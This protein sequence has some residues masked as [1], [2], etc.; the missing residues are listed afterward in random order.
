MKKFLLVIILLLSACAKSEIYMN[1]ELLI[2]DGAYE[3]ITYPITPHKQLN[4]YIKDY[5][6]SERNKCSDRLHVDNEYE[7]QITYDYYEYDTFISLLFTSYYYSNN[8]EITTY[9]PLTYDTQTN[10]LQ[11]MD[12][13]GYLNQI[14]F[15][16]N[17]T[18]IYYLEHDTLKS[19][20]YNIQIQLASSN[21]D[22][23]PL[24]AITFDDGPNKKIT[25]KMLDL[26]AKYQIKA[27]FFLIGEQIER[28]SEVVSRMIKEGHEIGNHTFSHHNI[29][30]LSTNELISEISKTDEALSSF[31]YQT[32]LF[33]PPY[34]SYTKECVS[35]ISKYFVTWDVDSRDWELLDSK[36]IYQKVVKDIGDNDIILFHDMYETTYD[37]LV[38]IIP[39]LIEQ[40]YEFVTVSELIEMRE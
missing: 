15:Y 4:T 30:K 3:R 28:N 32:K 31:N 6:Q 8:E 1:Q 18:N 38:K 36:K 35:N 2:N 21:L 5:I 23:K 20:Y 7:F 22:K 11:T 29:T 27:T 13:L 37:A 12:S 24:V 19:T 17:G 26:L 9:Y 16:Y 10:T 25:P 40:G 33:R 14:N 34:G 39:Y